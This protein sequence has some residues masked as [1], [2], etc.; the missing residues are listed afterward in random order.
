[1]AVE[2]TSMS[3]RQ[4]GCLPVSAVNRQRGAG[5]VLPGGGGEWD[6]SG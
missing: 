5:L 3:R 2:A 6:I 1:M 4:S